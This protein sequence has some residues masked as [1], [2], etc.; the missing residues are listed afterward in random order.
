M[1]TFVIK[2]ELRRA[3]SSWPFVIVVVIGTIALGQ[4]LYSYGQG[5][6][7]YLSANKGDPFLYN[8]FDALLMARLGVI[9]ILAP[10]LAA[11]PFADSLIVDRNSGFIRSMLLRSGRRKYVWSKLLATILV[12]GAAIAVPH[13]VIYGL[14][15]AIFPEGLSTTFGQQRMIVTGPLSDVYKSNPAL[16]VWFNILISFIFGAVYAAIGMLVSCISDNRYIALASPFMFYIIMSFI[17]ANLH[18]GLEGWLPTATF[19]PQQ[20]TN[21]TWVSIFGQFSAILL[22]CVVA[23]TLFARYKLEFV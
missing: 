21:T 9:S 17:I 16:Y 15:S 7:S 20:V 23:I 1:E 11:L 5:Y 3:F 4:G 2:V 18:G 6:Q 19:T 22:V 13:I 10:L 12:G 14:A 8:S